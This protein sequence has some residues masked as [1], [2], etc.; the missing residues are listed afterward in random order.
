MCIYMIYYDNVQQPLSLNRD[1]FSRV[2]LLIF[3]FS[4]WAT[5]LL[6]A[7][8]CHTPPLLM[9]KILTKLESTKLFTF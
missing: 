9:A 7:A 8:A 3:F 2:V 4:V 5:G 1:Y 6:R